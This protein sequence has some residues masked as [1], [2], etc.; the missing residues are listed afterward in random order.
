MNLD[1][2]WPFKLTVG[3]SKDPSKGAC[4]LDAVSWF[5]DGCLNDCLPCVSPVLAL[6]GQAANDWSNDE[7]RQELRRFIPLLPGTVNPVADEIRLEFLQYA[8]GKLSALWGPILT[9]A[10]LYGPPV[11]F[12]LGLE[13]PPEFSAQS[14][15]G[16]LSRI[17]RGYYSIQRCTLAAHHP[18]TF[19]WG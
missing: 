14:I 1:D 8:V 5:E 18:V 19:P 16:N 11:Q 2:L 15:V 13:Q 10:D 9:S 17:V 3:H 7:Q 6:L 12:D 4:L